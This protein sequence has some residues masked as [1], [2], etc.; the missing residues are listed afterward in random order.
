MGLCW[1]GGVAGSGLPLIEPGL[2]GPP[3][4]PIERGKRGSNS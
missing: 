1:E 2:G 3:N 4:A